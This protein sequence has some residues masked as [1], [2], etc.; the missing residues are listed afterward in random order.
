MITSDEGMT[1]P[2]I[3][4]YN[5]AQVDTVTAGG[6]TV[7]RRQ[8]QRTSYSAS[9]SHLSISGGALY[10][11]GT[12]DMPGSGRENSVNVS[13]TYT[14][15]LYAGLTLTYDSK[16]ES[17]GSG[18]SWN[19]DRGLFPNAMYGTFSVTYTDGT[20]GSS[21]MSVGITIKDGTVTFNH[22]FSAKVEKA[23]LVSDVTDEKTGRLYN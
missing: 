4:T 8:V 9:S 1:N 14:W 6:S 12:Y 22:G 13:S 23:V 5:G 18:L 16:N 7:W 2:V 20:T 19:I 17:I 11:S 15:T 3:I 21:L 10:T